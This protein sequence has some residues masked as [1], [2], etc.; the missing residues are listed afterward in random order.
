MAQDWDWYG[1][2]ERESIVVQEVSAVAVYQ[3]PQGDIVIRQ[4]SGITDEDSLIVIPP[5]S[6]D[7]LIK[8]LREAKKKQA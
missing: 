6:I 4:K 7:A 5:S 8:A 2:S 3:N 1:D